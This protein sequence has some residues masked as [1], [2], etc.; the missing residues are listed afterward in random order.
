MKPKPSKTVATIIAKGAVRAENNPHTS[1]LNAV[2]WELIS[3]SD[4]HAGHI[5]RMALDRHEYHH[6]V[7]R[8][9]DLYNRA[10]P[11]DHAVYNQLSEGPLEV[12]WGG[13]V[14]H[15]TSQRGHNAQATIHTGHLLHYLLIHPQS[16]L[17]RVVAHY[18]LTPQLVEVFNEGLPAEEEYYGELAMLESLAALRNRFEN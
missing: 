16:H 12:L 10:E 5:L 14:E 15:Y 9:A 3:H 7:L 1:L 18:D 13:L 8:L 17:G 11:I 4:N 6:I 2:G